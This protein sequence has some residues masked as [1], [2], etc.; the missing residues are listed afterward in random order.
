MAENLERDIFAVC[1][2]LKKHGKSLDIVYDIGANDGRWTANV[3]KKLPA[4]H[5]YQWEANPSCLYRHEASNVTRYIQVLSDQDNQEVHFY[6]PDNP[7]TSNTGNSYYQENTKHYTKGKFITLPTIKL[8][9]FV[10]EKEIP[11]PNFVKMDTQGSEVDIIRGGEKTLSHA[12]AIHCEVPLLEYNKG[13]PNFSDYQ[14]AFKSI[15]F[16]ATGVDHIAMRKNVV[17]QMDITFM[18]ED[19]LEEMY[20]YTER[21]NKL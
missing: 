7:K 19:L 8:D 10:R 17:S 3:G 9:T 5:F 21:Y 12:Y 13:A 4:K 14:A 18:R 20:K 16:F 2:D 6:T 15:G 11:L 1:K